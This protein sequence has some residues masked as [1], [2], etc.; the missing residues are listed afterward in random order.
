MRLCVCDQKSLHLVM[1]HHRYV[2]LKGNIN[3]LKPDSCIFHS[4]VTQ[5]QPIC[6]QRLHGSLRSFFTLI[7]MFVPPACLCHRC[8]C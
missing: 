3:T 2:I 6:K 4:C 1:T 5:K 7:H 8:Q